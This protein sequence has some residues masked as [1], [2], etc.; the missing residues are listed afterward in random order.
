[1]KPV[2]LIR[3][4]FIIAVAGMSGW[5]CS[6]ELNP[7]SPDFQTYPVVYSV[8]EVHRDTLAV[9]VTRS[10]LGKGSALDLAR[11]EDSV[12]FP[13][14]RVW[15]EKWNG[16]FRVARAELVKAELSPKESGIFIEKPNWEYIVVR[17]NET[18]TLFSGSLSSLEYHLTVEIP[19]MPLI[20]ASAKAYPQAYLQSPR[21]SFNTN[22]FLDPLQ[23]E[24]TNPAP[25][26]ELYFR[27]YYSDVYQD[28][29]INRSLSWREYH[30]AVAENR[31][32][33]SVFGQDMM[34]RIAAQVKSDPQ[35]RY[36]HVTGFQVV[37]VGIPADLFDYRNMIE[38]APSDQIGFPV[39][40]MVNAIGLFTSQ[41]LIAYDLTLDSGSCD[42][43]MN[44][45]FTRHLNFRFY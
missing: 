32:I 15:L 34:K 38:N 35:V 16:D 6:N 2:S 28:T 30:S 8:L 19:G 5:S 37:I 27:M 40:N 18:E 25:Y 42:S 33:E 26:S 23:F 4:I 20:Y 11:I 29:S 17:S 7:L 21:L 9:R 24:W 14:A 22:L 45:R 3:N 31:A 39:T 13:D 12:Y 10:F 36:R 43:I 41:T 44:G 1:M